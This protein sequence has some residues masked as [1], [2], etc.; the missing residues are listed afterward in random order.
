MQKNTRSVRA[1]VWRLTGGYY[2]E[3]PPVLELIRADISDV[4]T[5]LTLY[6]L[7]HCTILFIRCQAFCVCEI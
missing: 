5:G 3:Q 4:G 7:L 1:L 2:G 6:A